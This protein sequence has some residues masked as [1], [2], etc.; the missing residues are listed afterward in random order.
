[1]PSPSEP[2][3]VQSSRPVM[4]RTNG[5]CQVPKVEAIADNDPDAMDLD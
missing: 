2:M 3:T 4:H 5:S 1:V